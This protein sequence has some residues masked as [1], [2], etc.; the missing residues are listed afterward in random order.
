MVYV[1]QSTMQQV[2]HHR[3]SGRLQYALAERAVQFGWP[4]EAVVVD[5]DDQGCSGTSR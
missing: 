3:E 2:E 4:R 1:R 5:D